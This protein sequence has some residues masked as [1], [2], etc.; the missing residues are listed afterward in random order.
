MSKTKSAR[1]DK[2]KEKRL[3]KRQAVIVTFLALSLVVAGGVLA[4]RA[5]ILSSG[6]DSDKTQGKGVAPQSFSAA[7]PS[8]EYIYAGNKLIATEEPTSGG[9][10]GTAPAISS[11]TPSSA[12][13]STS[14]SLAIAGSN[15]AGASSINVS[16][17][18]DITITNL[19]SSA[20]QVTASVTIAASAVTG[21]RDVS[22]TVGAQTSNTLPFTIT[23]QPPVN[24]VPHLDSISPSSVRV[25]S[26]NFTLT[27]NGTNFVTG[28][29]ALIN[30]NSR[31]ITAQS[32]TTLS[33]AIPSTDILTT[34]TRGITVINP[35]PGGGTSNALTLTVTSAGLN[36]KPVIS[37]ISP[38]SVTFGGQGFTLTVNGSGF[39]NT[40]GS[41]IVRFDG[42]NRQTSF[43]NATQLTA[44]ITAQ[45]IATVGPHYISVF[46]PAP[47]GGTSGQALLTVLP[48][49]GGGGGGTGLRGDYFNN[50]IVA[51]TPALSRTDPTVN[52][53]W[54]TGSP[55][56]PVNSDHFSVRW[57]GQVKPQFSETYTFYV[58][59]DDGVRLWVNNQLMVDKW[60]NQSGAEWSNTIFL[61]GDSNY[62]IRMD[63]YDNSGNAEAH[64][65][66]SSNS[67]PK[68]IV[69][70]SQLYAGSGTQPLYVG[71]HQITNCTSIS[72]W[73]ADQAYLNTPISVDI[74][75]GT[76]LLSTVY[77]DLY[78]AD[79]AGVVGDNGLHGFTYPVPSALR[80]G[81]THTISVKYAA[82]TSNLTGSPQ[83]FS[84]GGATVP[85]GPTALMAWPNS[86]NSIGLNWHDNAVN[87]DGF[88]IERK[89]G[90]GGTYAE[91]GTTSANIVSFN[92]PGRTPGIVYYYRVRAFNNIG[93]SAYSNET[94]ATVSGSASNVPNPP[95]N[96]SVTLITGTRIN[97]QW[98]DNSDNENNFRV[99]KLKTGGGSWTSVVVLPAHNGLPNTVSY[100]AQ[101]LTPLTQYTFRV[102]ANNF[103]GD[104][105]PSNSVTATTGSGSGCGATAPFS[106]DG[107]QSG[108]GYGYTEGPGLSSRWRSPVAAV[109]GIDPVS[110]MNALFVVDTENHAIRMIYIDGPASG[111]SI[112]LAGSGI[113]GNWDGDGDPY[114]ARF[115]NPRGIT[116]ITNQ[117]GVV[118]AL[119]I[120]DTDNHVIRRLLPPLGGTRWRVGVFCGKGNPGYG[121]GDFAN[122][123]FNT[124]VGLTIG[125]EGLIYV[126]DSGN[127]AVR[128][129]DL[130]G[131]STTLFKQSIGFFQPVGIAVSPLSAGVFVTDQANHQIVEVTTGVK[132]TL[133]GSGDPGYHDANGTGAQF[134]TPYHLVWADTGGAG[135]LYIADYNNNRIRVLDLS[136][137]HTVT[138]WAGNGA[139]GYVNGPCSSTSFNL[140]AGVTIAPAGEL[141]VSDMGNNSVRKVS[142]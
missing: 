100:S 58:S 102:I 65:K 97:L 11:L 10:G 116:A 129:L 79:A 114:K 115:N 2:R 59:T 104:S 123:F 67:T 33:V 45:D 12:Q 82:T 125:A 36:P 105:L 30:G 124:P 117:S 139:A 54:G 76:T 44:Q 81:Q 35:A 132:T 88:K 75:D 128:I 50:Q 7:L 83:A 94:S 131:N 112:L 134:Y 46:N 136:S 31:T 64:L 15:L 137:T 142:E 66:W 103:Q 21:A 53:N 109:A 17:S 138:T 40:N 90:A 84:C 52:F 101:G 72:G 106:G 55:G 69:P 41:S 111:Y 99:E 60:S 85:S 28:C 91:I 113:A 126:A 140:P 4:Q 107:S 47:G 6:H 121:N 9:G 14:I 108:G 29:S 56:S 122:T 120:A 89:N 110:G 118:D 49:G 24:P 5:R 38:S 135:S 42:S 25:G 74:Y 77:A 61:I 20:N 3:T 73:A 87:E 96:L 70:M 127:K 63:Y 93:N 57:I 16:P 78:N 1:R 51:G 23:Q 141:Y 37:S 95:S 27:I 34:G 18:N 48:N 119:L 71:V 19:S 130:A 80:D 8:K 39:I 22:V 32:A 133:A 13:Q 92:D 68:Q 98:T 86:P 62:N 26:G 43:V